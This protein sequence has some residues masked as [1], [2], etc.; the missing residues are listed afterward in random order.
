MLTTRLVLVLS[1]VALGAFEAWRAEPLPGLHPLPEATPHW[2]VRSAGALLS[3]AA[4][5]LLAPRIQR[6]PAIVLGAYWLIF[7]AL[8]F[9]IAAAHPAEIGGWV[10]GA[11]CATFAALALAQLGFPIIAR[12][13]FAAMLI[14]FGAIHLTNVSFI[15]SLIPDWIP[16][17]ASWPWATGAAQIAAGLALL[18]GR[19]VAPAGFAIAAMYA[20]WLALVHAP[21]IAE[22]PTSLFEWTF[23]LTALALA[24]GAAEIAG[25]ARIA[26]AERGR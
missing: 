8:A 11:E 23:A 1:F 25:R 15:A 12:A 2:I 6:I 3:V 22:S 17:A 13:T 4:L 21:R 14:L 26:P 16:F 24:A 19:F 20:A 5:A 10:S 9:A 18:S 7:A